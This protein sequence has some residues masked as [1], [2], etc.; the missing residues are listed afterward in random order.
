MSIPTTTSEHTVS[1]IIPTLKQLLEAMSFANVNNLREF[2]GL[3]RQM[4]RPADAGQA[5]PP[6]DAAPVHAA[7]AP[8]GESA[9]GAL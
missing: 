5:R 1:T 9:Q 2:R 8:A 4:D 3:L 6:H 7:I